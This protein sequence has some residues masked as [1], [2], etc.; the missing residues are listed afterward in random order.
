M[1]SKE[2]YNITKLD[3]T[4]IFLLFVKLL[5]DALFVLKVEFLFF[6][7]LKSESNHCL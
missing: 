2:W 5:F 7:L 4:F 1:I 6:S 3:Q